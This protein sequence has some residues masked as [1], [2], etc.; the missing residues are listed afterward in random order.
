MRRVEDAMENK[1]L[2]MQS[3]DIIMDGNGGDQDGD[4]TSRDGTHHTPTYESALQTNPK[5][6]LDGLWF[7]ALA[8][9]AAPM[10]FTSIWT[11]PRHEHTREHQTEF[12]VPL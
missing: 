8:A 9:V 2:E 7:L 10:C 11:A 12:A 1:E 6:A 4:G 3:F 5:I